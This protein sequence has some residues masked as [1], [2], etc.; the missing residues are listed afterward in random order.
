MCSKQ[1]SK[2]QSVGK[3]LCAVILYI[4]QKLQYIFNNNNKKNNKVIPTRTFSLWRDK[5][6]SLFPERYKVLYHTYNHQSTKN[7]EPNLIMPCKVA[8][9]SSL[10]CK[11]WQK[12]PKELGT[13][14]LLQMN[15]HTPLLPQKF[16]QKFFIY[17][18]S[19]NSLHGMTLCYPNTYTGT[20]SELSL[21]KPTHAA[22]I[23]VTG[24]IQFQNSSTIRNTIKNT[25]RSVLDEEMN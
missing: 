6:T 8:R 25:A 13:L 10:L 12:L 5:Q 23:H 18:G 21:T 3:T 9:P 16:C 11:S 22:Y 17:K 4:I 2:D 14:F 1:C 20:G 19:I 24:F 15:T 7:S